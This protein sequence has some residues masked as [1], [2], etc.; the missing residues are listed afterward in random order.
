MQKDNQGVN[1]FPSPSGG[2]EGKFE[3]Q[4]ETYLVLQRSEHSQTTRLQVCNAEEYLA[5]DKDWQNISVLVT[6]T[7][8]EAKIFKSQFH[9]AAKRGATSRSVSLEK[10]AEIRKN[11]IFTWMHRLYKCKDEE[12]EFIRVHPNKQPGYSNKKKRRSRKSKTD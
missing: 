12:V 5:G 9:T 8:T 11:E 1:F 2:V 3:Q 6:K 4:Q 7:P 10:V